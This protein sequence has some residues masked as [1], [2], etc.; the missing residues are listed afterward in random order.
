M[1]SLVSFYTTFHHAIFSRLQ[2]L[3]GLAPLL[4][5]LFPGPSNDCHRLAQ[6]PELCRY[7]CLV[8]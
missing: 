2:Y 7:G 8:W 4:L 3:D 6:I 1:N 5:R